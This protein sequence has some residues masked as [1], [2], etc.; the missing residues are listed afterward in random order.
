V[1]VCLLED[2]A[3]RGE[4]NLANAGKSDLVRV[5][6]DALQRATGP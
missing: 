5:Q 4:Q 2:R 1:V 3:T 6:R